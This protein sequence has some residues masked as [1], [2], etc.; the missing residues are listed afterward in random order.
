MS[1]RLYF[2][3]IWMKTEYGI[4]VF[5]ERNETPVEEMTQMIWT[6]YVTCVDSVIPFL[7]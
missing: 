4:S 2:N 7:F 1:F 5:V 6:L 3:A